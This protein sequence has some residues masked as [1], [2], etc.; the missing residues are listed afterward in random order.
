[1]SFFKPPLM[2]LEALIALHVLGVESSNSHTD[3][4][5]NE[6]HSVAL[7]P[8]ASGSYDDNSGTT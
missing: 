8:F 2:S 3:K 5:M 7:L 4:N 1:M 6:E